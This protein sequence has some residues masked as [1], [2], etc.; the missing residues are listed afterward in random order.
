MSR[1]KLPKILVIVGVCLLGFP[2]GF[3][4]EHGVWKSISWLT[5]FGLLLIAGWLGYAAWR[6]GGWVNPQALAVRPWGYIVCLVAILLPGAAVFAEMLQFSAM[7][8][9]VLILLAGIGRVLYELLGAWPKVAWR[10][11]FGL[12]TIALWPFIMNWLWEVG[13][14]I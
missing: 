8:I 2:L 9:A 10:T 6:S 14:R 12:V 1:T 7:A 5:G 4:H 11:W 13:H 3:V